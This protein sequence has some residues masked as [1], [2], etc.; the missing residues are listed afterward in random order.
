MEKVG[1]SIIIPVFNEEESISELF[2]KLEAVLGGVN[3]S[4]E[5]I[6]IDDG[7]TDKTLDVIREMGA[8]S[9]RLKAIS[10]KRNFG[11]SAALMAGFGIS[12]QEANGE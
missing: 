10:F 1:L 12:F 5:V 6:F 7:S 3:K 11:K 2:Q 4:C 8:K 9:G